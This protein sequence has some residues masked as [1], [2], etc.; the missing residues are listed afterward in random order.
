VRD[1]QG[2]LAGRALLEELTEE[3]SFIA[4]GGPPE[5]NPSWQEA[6]DLE[7][8]LTVARLLVESALAR[9]ESRG[10]HYRS[11]FPVRDDERWLQA[12]VVRRGDDGNPVLGTRPVELT[13]L[14]TD[15]EALASRA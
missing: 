7:N 1:K 6:L 3:T 13:R 2:L 15:G 11:D 10:A 14:A 8:Q 9:E 4:A 5:A 12:V